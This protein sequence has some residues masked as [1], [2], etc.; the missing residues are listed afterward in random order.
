MDSLPAWI[1][2]SR[3]FEERCRIAR[4][5]FA[6]VL[7]FIC[8]SST[9][10]RAM[11]IKHQQ[12][13]FD[14]GMQGIYN[15]IGICA[16]HPLN[17]YDPTHEHGTRTNILEDYRKLMQESW[18]VSRRNVVDEA[19][20]PGFTGQEMITEQ[21]LPYIDFYQA[22][23]A[24]GAMT[25]MEHD[26]IMKLVEQGSAVKIPLFEYVYHEYAGVRIDGF[27]LPT[28]CLGVPY[29]HTVAYVAL[30]GGL[31]EFN[32][33]CLRD[34]YRNAFLNEVDEAMVR[35]V[36][37]LGRARLTYGKDYLVYGRMAR[38]P[39]LGVAR[40]AFPF[41]TPLV[42]NWTD[43]GGLKEG[44]SWLDPVVCSAFSH[45]DSVAIFLC[46]ITEE[47]QTVRFPLDAAKLYGIPQGTVSI[48]R[49]GEECCA[50]TSLNENGVLELSLELSSRAVYTILVRKA[51]EE[52]A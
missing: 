15:D 24:G 19:G 44:E 31:P 1:P 6:V 52:E 41:Q 16:V 20:N 48:L 35:F 14:L 23:S 4:L 47:A 5:R 11:V 39:D 25:G 26:L 49:D 12:D 36:G 43:N 8:A 32:Y 38:T 7:Q 27:V 33:E 30:N 28:S 46:N 21:F 42:I 29:Y 10:W 22:R 51:S 40:R 2:A 34:A 50:P 37:L 9:P 13:Q 45:G 18:E 17:C 3:I